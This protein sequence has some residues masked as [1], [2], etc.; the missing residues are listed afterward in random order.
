MLP[1]AQSRLLEATTSMS[2]SNANLPAAV[3]IISPCVLMAAV[4]SGSP[5]VAAIG[6]VTVLTMVAACVLD[7]QS[8]RRTIAGLVVE[9]DAE[10]L[11]AAEAQRLEADPA[12]ADAKRLL[13]LVSR[14]D[15]GDGRLREVCRASLA[16]FASLT[17]SARSLDEAASVHS[18]VLSDVTDTDTS[19]RL[20]AASG[21]VK[22]QARA[23][24]DAA[25]SLHVE[26]ALGDLVAPTQ[27]CD[28]LT[29]LRE[30]AAAE[31]EVS[32][33]A[34]SPAHG[35]RSSNVT[36]QPGHFLH[37]EG[38]IGPPGSSIDASQAGQT[39]VTR[40]TVPRVD[41]TQWAPTRPT[42]GSNHV[43]TR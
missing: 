5:V 39:P 1:T 31:R 10:A 27:S 14:Y 9:V 22:A 17:A 28:A 13:D 32:L 12:L 23:L 34:P 43:E 20:R 19:A 4:C 6:M 11:A 26:C 36:P 24:L 35:I 30:R 16:E 8:R 25:I 40:S 2:R 15:A 3:V 7:H 29:R 38:S 33:A 37:I 41:R 21:R 18:R 42:I